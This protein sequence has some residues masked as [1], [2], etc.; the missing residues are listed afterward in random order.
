MLFSYLPLVPAGSGMLRPPA[1]TGKRPGAGMNR[2][3][4]GGA[5]AARPD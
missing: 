2:R 1:K 4:A 3:D 5:D